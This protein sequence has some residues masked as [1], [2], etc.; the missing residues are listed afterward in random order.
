[1]IHLKQMIDLIFFFFFPLK[2]FC[3]MKFSNTT[4][5]PAM[6]QPTHG[7]PVQAAAN[8]GKATLNLG[9]FKISDIVSN[10]GLFSYAR[11]PPAGDQPPQAGRQRTQRRFSLISAAKCQA[12]V[13]NGGRS[14]TGGHCRSCDGAH[15]KQTN[16]QDRRCQTLARWGQIW[17]AV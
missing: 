15:S 1:M 17:L 6:C 7:R 9:G 11:R 12:G 2:N 10:A 5:W 16:R 14:N 13:C 4:S 3:K 8:C